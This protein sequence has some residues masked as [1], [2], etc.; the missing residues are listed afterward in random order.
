[1]PVEVTVDLVEFHGKPFA[2]ASIRDVSDQRR[3]EEQMRQ[4]QKMESVGTLAAGV[5]HD[6]NNIL[7]VIQ[8]CSELLSLNLG[9]NP[10]PRSLVEQ[11]QA[12]VRRASNLVRS[13][14]AFS[15]EE[16]LQL[17]RFSF[18]DLILRMGEFLARVIG[19]GVRIEFQLC[20]DSTVVEADAGQ[21][22]QVF[23]NLAVNAR[24]A[25]GG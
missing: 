16:K 18:N 5:A 6:F 10:A 8:G 7:T 12:A 17:Q 1:F 23:V 4:A 21:W 14:L 11:I 2:C 13:L 15:R 19:D 24:D 9:N 3:V 25:M 20:D 22:E